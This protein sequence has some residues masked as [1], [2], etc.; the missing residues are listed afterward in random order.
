M[1]ISVDRD[2]EAV[3]VPMFGTLVPFHIATIKS[4]TTSTENRE[5][6]LRLNFY[7]AGQVCPVVAHALARVTPAVTSDT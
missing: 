6:F 3:L 7:N 2:H 1:Q 5:T 4:V